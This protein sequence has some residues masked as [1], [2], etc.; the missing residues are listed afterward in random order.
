MDRSRSLT[1]A[2][3]SAPATLAALASAPAALPALAIL[4]ALAS[5][6]AILSDFGNEIESACPGGDRDDGRHAQG[7]GPVR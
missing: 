2:L 4:P 3:A 7:R 1:T 6:P 5:A